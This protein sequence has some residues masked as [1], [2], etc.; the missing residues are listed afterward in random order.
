[1]NNHFIL[2]IRIWLLSA[3]ISCYQFATW[4]GKNLGNTIVG[5]S[6]YRQSKSDIAYSWNQLHEYYTDYWMFSKDV[7]RCSCRSFLYPVKSTLFYVN[8]VMVH[9]MDD[10][11]YIPSMKYTSQ[12][13]KNDYKLR[14]T[15]ITLGSLGVGNEYS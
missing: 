5:L 7:L 9:P 12:C 15:K 8:E 11:I 10:T 6:S 2:I 4:K 3:C 14:I 1:M 13:K